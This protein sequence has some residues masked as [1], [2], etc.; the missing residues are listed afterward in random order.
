MNENN[1]SNSAGMIHFPLPDPA[2]N[3]SWDSP[4]E[5]EQ[6][7]SLCLLEDSKLT[8]TGQTKDNPDN[9]QK[10]ELNKKSG[11]TKMR[12][13]KK[14]ISRK[15]DATN[16]QTDKMHGST[17]HYGTRESSQSEN[18]RWESGSCYKVH[19]ISSEHVVRPASGHRIDTD[20]HD[21]DCE[22]NQHVKG[23]YE[24]GILGPFENDETWNRKHDDGYG[25]K[26]SDQNQRNSIS[27][28]CTNWGENRTQTYVPQDG[29]S[30]TQGWV[31][32][33]EKGD[34]CQNIW[35]HMSGSYR[36]RGKDQEN[37]ENRYQKCRED[38][39][40][41]FCDEVWRTEKNSE[42]D[43]EKEQG[44]SRVQRHDLM[45]QDARIYK[46]EEASSFGRDERLKTEVQ[47]DLTKCI[48]RTQLP[49]DKN[50]NYCY[51]ELPVEQFLNLELMSVPNRP[52]DVAQV[53]G[54][55]ICNAHQHQTHSPPVDSATTVSQFLHAANSL[56]PSVTST[57]GVGHSTSRLP[58][59]ISTSMPHY[60]NTACQVPN[61]AFQ[62]S[63]QPIPTANIQELFEA[64]VREQQQC[65]MTMNHLLQMAVM[66]HIGF[67]NMQ[68]DSKLQAQQKLSAPVKATPVNVLGGH[69][70]GYNDLLLQ[71]SAL[72][73][74]SVAPVL[75][76]S[77]LGMNRSFAPN[78]APLQ[79]DVSLSV[80]GIGSTVQTPIPNAS[81]NMNTAVGTSPDASTFMLN[82]GNQASNLL[83]MPSSFAIDCN[84]MTHQNYQSICT[85]QRAVGNMNN[86][87]QH[88]APGPYS[89][90]LGAGPAR[91]GVSSK[92]I[93]SKGRGRLIM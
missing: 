54:T 27:A 3:E 37:A 40:A 12:R 44:N 34:H 41:V 38:D 65:M 84:S 51:S 49:H 73:N 55:E 21:C 91:E 69:S 26:K 31:D 82:H 11:S 75:N 63:S 93:F 59:V 77:L 52:Q 72:L 18:G 90:P 22:L 24:E 71:N 35:E 45:S 32:W 16:L 13:K 56:L 61:Q 74:T 50:H 78:N 58:P 64:F 28:P 79:S 43:G 89:Q 67:S 7:G 92:I 10:P 60:P 2:E 20:T 48:G 88:L 62:P 17:G 66:N 23:E 6:V 36:N 47:S 83:L 86:M 5:M 19:H 68:L 33:N 29:N 9:R 14:G 87:M 85:E 57:A 80:T 42:W 25:I 39:R 53:F 4:E 46:T 1:F 81:I 30:R 76:S 8:V 15:N 70:A